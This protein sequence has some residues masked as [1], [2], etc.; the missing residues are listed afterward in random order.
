MPRLDV[1]RSAVRLPSSAATANPSMSRASRRAGRIWLQEA[2]RVDG[3]ASVGSLADDVEAAVRTLALPRGPA[4]IGGEHRPT[5]DNTVADPGERAS[6]RQRVAA[7]PRRWRLRPALHH[8]SRSKSPRPPLDRLARRAAE[9]EELPGS[10]STRADDR[11][12]AGGSSRWPIETVTARDRSRENSRSGS[13]VVTRASTPRVAEERPQSDG[14]AG[15]SGRRASRTSDVL[16]PVE[17]V[18]RVGEM[19]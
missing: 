6:G 2:D 7:D 9:A 1:T 15:R 14:G 4:V 8:L 18:G 16:L 19:T 12:V 3:G 17:R 5:H 13:A 10:A 11:P